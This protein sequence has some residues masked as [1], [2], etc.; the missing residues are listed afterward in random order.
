MPVVYHDNGLGSPSVAPPGDRVQGPVCSALS[1]ADCSPSA[2]PPPIL[3][4]A[5]RPWWSITNVVGYGCGNGRR[6]VDG[7]LSTRIPACHVAPPW[8]RSVRHADSPFRSS[9][10]PLNSFSTGTNRG[11]R[12]PSYRCWGRPS[13]AFWRDTI[14]GRL[15]A[16]ARDESMIGTFR[17]STGKSA[18]RRLR[19]RT[20]P[21]GAQRA[22]SPDCNPNAVH[23]GTV[24]S[25][26]G[27]RLERKDERD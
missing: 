10:R 15:M 16:T 7:L 4:K 25:S 1:T 12:P 3:R 5:I 9:W 14:C 2:G 19:S 20:L 21:M 27:E 17:N 23:R 11:I 8:Y 18:R 26:F 6:T 24:L 13:A 22:L